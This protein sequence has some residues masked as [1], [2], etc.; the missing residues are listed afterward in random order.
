MKLFKN[1]LFLTLLLSLLQ[2]C[3]QDVKIPNYEYSMPASIQALRKVQQKESLVFG[4]TAIRGMVTSDAGAK[5]SDNTLLIVQDLVSEAA[6]VVQLGFANT[7]LLMGDVVILDLEGATLKEIEGELV[8]VQLERERIQVESSGNMLRPKTTS[9]ATLLAN[10]RYWGPILVKLDKVNIALGEDGKLKGRLLIDDE[11]VEIM[12]DFKEGSVFEGEDNP[13]FVEAMV[14]IAR[15]EGKNVVLVPRN[16]EDIQVGLKELLEDFEQGSNTN[17]DAKSMNFVT[18]SWLVDGGITATS[19]ADPKNG[20]QS[21]RLQGTVGNS[22]RNGIIAMN[23]DLKGVKTIAVS[24]GIY[25]AAAETGNVNPT[26][27]A[28]EMSKDGGASYTLV[29]TTEIDNKSTVL[30][31]VQFPINAGF[32]ENVRFRIVNTSLPFANNNRPRINIDDVHFNF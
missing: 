18:G 20:K 21:I 8:V 16:L 24:Y 28:L 1:L 12:A 32:S 2:G 22:K 5:N 31:T 30:S 26:V 7:D 15:L 29:G 4:K 14:G 23:F 6:I 17:Y 9:M 11:I 25:P 13:E 19:T 10:V 27:F 3:R